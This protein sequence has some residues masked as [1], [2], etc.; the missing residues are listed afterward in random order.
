MKI[1]SILYYQKFIFEYIAINNTALSMGI[2]RNNERF[3]FC[4]VITT[5]ASW[6]NNK[7]I[8]ESIII[9]VVNGDLEQVRIGN[10]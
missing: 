8:F 7:V 3:L 5:E 6:R 10:G 2:L 4:C 1:I 9:G